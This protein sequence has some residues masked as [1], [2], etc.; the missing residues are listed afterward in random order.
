MS[1]KKL[2]VKCAVKKQQHSNQFVSEYLLPCVTGVQIEMTLEI[3]QQSDKNV[4]IKAAWE[5]DSST[6]T[7]FTLYCYLTDFF[8]PHQQPQYLLCHLSTGESGSV[9]NW[10]WSALSVCSL[11]PS[12]LGL[13]EG[14]IDLIRHTWVLIT[15][16]AK[17]LWFHRCL[18][19][20]VTGCCDILLLHGQ[21]DALP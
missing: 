4:C 21:T 1:E 17:R 20:Q 5:F 12:W 3:F 6:N 8:S 18:P 15:S 16:R 10:E 2:K 14:H 9:D 13:E 7:N 19:A 11:Q